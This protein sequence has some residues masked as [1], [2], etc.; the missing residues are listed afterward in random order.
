V[1]LG[2]ERGKRMLCEVLAAH[3]TC[4]LGTYMRSE[5]GLTQENVQHG[6]SEHMSRRKHLRFVPARVVDGITEK[7]PTNTLQCISS[8]L[9]LLSGFLL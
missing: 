1:W 4:R 2:E 7:K 9:L 6:R 5:E 8:V 3:D